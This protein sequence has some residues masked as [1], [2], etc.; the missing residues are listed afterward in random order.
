MKTFHALRSLIKRVALFCILAGAVLT[1]AEDIPEFVHVHQ[2]TYTKVKMSWSDAPADSGVVNFIVYRDNSPLLTTSEHS[3]LDT[4]LTPN[5]TYTYQITGV[6]GSG[7]P[8]GTA[9][10]LTLKTLKTYSYEGADTVRQ[11]VEYLDFVDIPS[12]TEIISSVESAFQNIFE[13]IVSL[14]TS[15]NY[16]IVQN[17]IQSTLDD[18]AEGDALTSTERTTLQQE[19]EEISTNSFNGNSIAEVLLWAKIV[20]I[21]EAHWQN[22]YQTAAK[23]LLDFSL[24]FLSD[25]ESCVFSTLWRLGYYK[26]HSLP[27][28]ATQQEVIAALQENTAILLRFFDFFPDSESNFAEQVY[29]RAAY[30]YYNKFPIVL[31][32]ATYDVGSYNAAIALLENAKALNDSELNQTRIEKFKKWELDSV[33]VTLKTPNGENLP[34]WLSVEDLDVDEIYGENVASIRE[35]TTGNTPA[36]LSIGLYKGHSYSM[37]ARVNSSPDGPVIFSIAEIP[38]ERGSVTT[39][40]NG[41]EPVVV[42]TGLDVPPEMVFVCERYETLEPKQTTFDKIRLNW[43][44]AYYNQEVTEY[45]VYRNNEVVHTTSDTFF[46]D[47]NLVDGCVYDYVIR[48]YDAQGA[49]LHPATHLNIRTMRK[50]NLDANDYDMIRQVVNY[51]AAIDIV[52]AGALIDAV[53]LAFQTL[54]GV[55]PTF[56]LFDRSIIET[57]VQRELDNIKGE[58]ERY[59][60]EQYDALRQEVDELLARHFGG[61]S[62]AE[63]YMY[64]SLGHLGEQHWQEGKV[65][66]AK[67]L[68]NYSLNFVF[69]V[70]SMVFNTLHRLGYYLSHEVNSDSPKADIK[71]KLAEIKTNFMRFFDEFFPESSTHIAQQVYTQCSVHYFN[72]FPTLLP[73]DNYDFDTYNT[74][75]HLASSALALDSSNPM[76]TKRLNKYKAWG[77]GEIN[78]SFLS[79]EGKRL[80][81]G[82]TILNTSSESLYP[83]GE[84]IHDE[85]YF[86]SDSN[87]DSALQVPIYK[88]HTYQLTCNIEF[89]QAGVP[90][91][92]VVG[93][94]P[95]KYGQRAIFRLGKEPIYENLLN[96]DAPPEIVFITKDSDEDGL[97]DYEEVYLYNSNPHSIDSD[98]DGLS[99]YFEAVVSHTNC[100]SVDSDN[101]GISDA[102]EDF[103]RDQLSNIEEQNSN[104][105]PLL[106]ALDAGGYLYEYVMQENAEDGDLY[107]WAEANTS[108]GLLNEEDP[109]YSGNRM[110]GFHPE[111]GSDTYHLQ[112]IRPKCAQSKVQWKMRAGES[113]EVAFT[114]QTSLGQRVLRYNLGSE[115]ELTSG[116]EIQYGLADQ[117]SN[118]ND[119]QTIR[120]D[121]QRDLWN[122]QPYCDLLYLI[123]ATFS[124]TGKIDELMTMEYADSDH[125]LLPDALEV[126]AGLNPNDHT[127]ARTD[128]DGDGI[129]NLAELMLKTNMGLADTDGDDVSDGQELVNQTD[130]LR[131][132]INSYNHR[133]EVMVFDDAE[134][135]VSTNWSLANG[136][137]LTNA[138]TV[139]ERERAPSGK[140]AL[141]IDSP[142]IAVC[143]SL[144]SIERTYRK[145]HVDLK[146]DG[147]IEIH[148]NCMTSSGWRD[149]YYTLS[150]TSNLGT[151][152][153]VHFGVASLNQTGEWFLIRRDIAKDLSTAQPECEILYIKDIRF[154]GQ[155]EIDN[156]S[157]LAYPDADHDLIPDAIEEAWGL[158][159]TNDTDAFEDIDLDGFSNFH[160]FIYGNE[161]GNRPPV[162][163]LSA[164][165]E[166]GSVPFTVAF[167]TELS[168]DPDGSIHSV[169]WDFGDQSLGNGSSVSHTYTSQGLY[170]AT[171]TL[172]D[173]AG[174]KST[175]KIMINCDSDASTA[176]PTTPT[177]LRIVG[178]G[179]NMLSLNWLPASSPHGIDKYQVYRNNKL[180][181]LVDDCGYVDRLNDLDTTYSYYVK[182]IDAN[183]ALSAT[184]VKVD[185]ATRKHIVPRYF[186]N[187][188][189]GDD[190]ANGLYSTTPKKTLAAAYNVAKPGAYIIVSGGDYAGNIE[191]DTKNAVVVKASD[192]SIVNVT[193][194]SQTDNRGMTFSS[195]LVDNGTIIEGINFIEGNHSGDGGGA[196]IL[197]ASPVIGLCSFQNNQGYD[198]GAVCVS[199][200][201]AKPYLIKCRLIE[202]SATGNGGGLCYKN[203]AKPR[204]F[205]CDIQNNNATGQGAGIYG[206]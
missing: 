24:N 156:L 74:T 165:P 80:A 152:T 60:A 84:I 123:S 112:L 163:K 40:Q 196:Y 65:D 202:N 185:F 5:T 23:G 167:D 204:V 119:W 3:Y 114:C 178:F 188:D 197:S 78:I 154:I 46:T 100:N 108:S 19:L 122:A 79:L 150:S 99:D 116:E 170:T 159:M 153:L 142:S 139:V 36:P 177:D 125:D 77:L 198:G 113:F 92:Y 182:A 76:H 32:Y 89:N 50:F 155:A 146:C 55:D 190:T 68:V 66:A 121:I 69:N 41:T 63:V 73:Y 101:D 203:N 194:R 83:M 201:E 88:G 12:A 94:L 13:L 21:A 137:E 16:E 131:P 33:K 171:V 176:I 62:M 151:G 189:F 93:D 54:F 17:G 26:M 51:V 191:F 48:A 106:T 1:N 11:I 147:N 4:G 42:N 75:I 157:L 134:N 64:E 144:D 7:Q 98:G 115:N 102:D 160:E 193:C 135:G 187:N 148:V 2:I 143:Y 86:Y 107:R 162:I 71:A 158:S 120:R 39:Y 6:D 49:E 81:G 25:V 72:Y 104:M 129:D 161:Q 105:N 15:F 117:L 110:I 45:K 132:A 61:H 149:I 14:S 28:D 127:D 59:T 173:N 85:R 141:K 175:R 56:Y 29:V 109:Y 200:D 82:V 52:D 67:T 168:Y 96:P 172:L 35:I 118:T 184:S 9:Y 90:I 10:T 103:D 164:T 199:G 97:S 37:T 44:G 133:H 43:S 186:V 20:E 179:R 58:V 34:A 183:A 174:A 130:P 38:R 136:A 126:T 128:V 169:S 8:V 18:L 57:Y 53:Q 95:H 206:K 145:F 205:A 30:D 140:N 31:D 181:A 166:A 87:N 138:I 124:G 27:D 111:N 180:I 195:R 47:I 192:D 70:E 91:P 22:G